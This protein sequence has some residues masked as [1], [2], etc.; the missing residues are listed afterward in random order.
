[1]LTLASVALYAMAACMIKCEA[2][3][4]TPR[5][6]GQ[7]VRCRSALVVR[8]GVQSSGGNLSY[9]STAVSIVCHDAFESTN[10]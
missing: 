5:V 1:M 8:H 2:R 3:I 7:R 9:E 4:W 10:I 6:N